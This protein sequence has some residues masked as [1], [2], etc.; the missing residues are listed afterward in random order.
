[1]LNNSLV[2]LTNE[3]VDESKDFMGETMKAI[4]GNMFND[5]DDTEVAIMARSLKLT[6]KSINLVKAYAEKLDSM[7][8]KMDELIEICKKR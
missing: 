8:R 1:M 4:G 2:T 7:D 3:L 6:N 5:M